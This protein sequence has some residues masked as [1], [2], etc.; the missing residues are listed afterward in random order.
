MIYS[1][2]FFLLKVYDSLIPAEPIAGLIWAEREGEGEDKR[3]KQKER[4][5]VSV[6]Q[7]DSVCDREREKER[8]REGEGDGEW[9]RQTEWVTDRQC[10]R[11]REREGGKMERELWESAELS[12]AIGHVRHDLRCRGNQDPENIDTVL[13][14][15]PFN[16]LSSLINVLARGPSASLD[17]MPDGCTGAVGSGSLTHSRGNADR[18]L[19]G[20]GGGGIDSVQ[21]NT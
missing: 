21:S 6:W 20:F 15:N 9:E 12:Q 2:C 19:G 16:Y 3:V 13:E 1:F 10:V 5:M 14:Q 4:E 11:E 17:M 7:T 8:E 18:A